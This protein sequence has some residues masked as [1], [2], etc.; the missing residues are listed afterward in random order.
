MTR[1][2]MIAAVE[3]ITKVDGPD[4]V[5]IPLLLELEDALPNADVWRLMYRSRVKRTSVEIVD[6]ALRLV[7]IPKLQLAAPQPK[8]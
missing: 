2:E 3:K 1:E 8:D 7:A 6:E 5:L 4:E